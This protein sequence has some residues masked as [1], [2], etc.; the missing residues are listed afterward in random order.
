MSEILNDSPKMSGGNVDNK[1]IIE[2]WSQHENSAD[3]RRGM[4]GYGVGFDLQR[5]YYQKLPE[6]EKRQ[7]EQAILIL[8]Q[9]N[10]VNKAKLALTMC[11]QF[12]GIFP[13]DWPKQV[14]TL[15]E[16]MVEKGLQPAY[17]GTITDAILPL[18]WKFCIHSLI[19]FVKSFREQITKNFKEGILLYTEWQQLYNQVSRI[20]S[21]E[22]HVGA[23]LDVKLL[24]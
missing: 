17:T 22:N 7:Y 19:P 5:E 13:E 2:I 4:G 10:D 20:L 9:D 6:N 16:K 18:I 21:V 24:P 3:A 14:T 8:C 1:Y 12:T 15:V 23:Y 11:S